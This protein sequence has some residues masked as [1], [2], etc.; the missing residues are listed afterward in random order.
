[1]LFSYAAGGVGQGAFSPVRG[2]GSL[3]KPVLTIDRKDENSEECID[4]GMGEASPPTGFASHDEGN[5]DNVRSPKG[6]RHK[7]SK[8]R[9]TKTQ[10][11]S[12][13]KKFEK[14]FKGWC[15]C[16][17]YFYITSAT[18]I[19]ISYNQLWTFYINLRGKCPW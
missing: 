13:R 1:M 17:D 16:C 3:S 5:A 14:Q 8:K 9:L 19:T 18:F 12:Q 11:R 15:E 7:V 10:K 6:L 4:V 2:D